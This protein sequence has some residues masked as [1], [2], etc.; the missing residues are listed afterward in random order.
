VLRTV[1]RQARVSCMAERVDVYGGTP[2]WSGL[3][4]TMPTM[5]PRPYY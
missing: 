4:A 3:G 1:L 2:A 5:R